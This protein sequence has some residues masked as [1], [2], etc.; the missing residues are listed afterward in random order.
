MTD[1]EVIRT[2]QTRSE[3]FLDQVLDCLKQK[4]EEAN[5]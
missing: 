1:I 3:A 2:G 4:E 5:V